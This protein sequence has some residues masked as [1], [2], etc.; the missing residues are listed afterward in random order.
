MYI[1]I[2]MCICVYIYCICPNHLNSLSVNPSVCTRHGLLTITNVLRKVIN[3]DSTI[4]VALLI[5]PMLIIIKT[6][7]RLVNLIIIS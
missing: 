4:S 5:L 6:A 3:T 2:Y 1:C 7:N